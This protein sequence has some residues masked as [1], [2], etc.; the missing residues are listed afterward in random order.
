MHILKSKLWKFGFGGALV[1]TSLTLGLVCW[2]KMASG[3]S[4]VA[5]SGVVHSNAHGGAAG[6]DERMQ[7]IEATAV[8]I[9]MG[10]KEPLRLSLAQLMKL[11]NVPALSVAVIED[12]KVAWAKGYGTIG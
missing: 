10:D 9:S 7:K 8:D 1:A 4:Y 2:A 12:F 5:V 3:Q 11:Y 6:P